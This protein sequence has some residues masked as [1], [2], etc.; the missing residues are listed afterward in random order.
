MHTR[1]QIVGLG[2]GGQAWLGQGEFLSGGREARGGSGLNTRH[3]DGTHT[4]YW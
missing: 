1:I 2:V 3:K 4:A